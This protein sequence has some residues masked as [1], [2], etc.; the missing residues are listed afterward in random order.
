MSELSEPTENAFG[1]SPPPSALESPS[2]FSPGA[3]EEAATAYEVKFLLTEAEAAEVAARVHGR[4]ALDPYADPA[5]GNAYLTTS[6]YTDTPNFDVF[7]RTD[8]YDRDKFRVRRYGAVGPVFVE[9]KTKNG[10]KVRKHRARINPD[11]VSELVASELNGEWAGEWFHSQLLQ[12]QLKPVCRIAYE[13][14]AYLGTADGGTVR[15]TFDRNVRGVLLSEWKLEPVG[16][17]APLLDRV[18]CEFKFRNTMPALFKGIV[19]DLKLTPTPVSKYR[20][21]V[22]ATGLAPVRSENG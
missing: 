16:A 5:M 19:A 17:V 8:G 21:F 2:L 22:R 14:V 18:V 9:R 15:L 3:T 11:D 6:V 7:Y 13:R 1:S 4:L 12:L 10:D 20:T